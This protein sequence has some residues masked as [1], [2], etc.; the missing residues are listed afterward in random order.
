MAC[1]T[2][3]EPV[4]HLIRGLKFHRRYAY[5]RLLGA[6]LAEKLTPRLEDLPQRIIP[7]PLHRG[8]YRE[9]GFNHAAEIARE[10][11]RRTGIPVDTGT[12]YRIRVTRPQVGLSAE[13]R[14]H[15]VRGAFELT[16][17]C[18]VRHVAILDDVVTT[19][20]TVNELARTLKQ[21]GAERVEVWTCARVDR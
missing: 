12:A 13:Q 15:N 8:R 9:R 17:P 16:A 14:T 10:V 4:R 19:G 11:S 6:L 18:A 5:G 3:E 21:G 2:Y 7:V 1:F 20:A